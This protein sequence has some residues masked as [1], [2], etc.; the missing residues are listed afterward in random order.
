[1]FKAAI[2]ALAL[3]GF[4]V[5]ASAQAPPAAAAAPDESPPSR[6]LELADLFSEVTVPDAALSPS[7]RYLAVVVRQANEDRLLINDL[8]PT[9]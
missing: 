6:P 2:A 7:G 3:Y 1:L 5:I 4:A 8:S 9:E